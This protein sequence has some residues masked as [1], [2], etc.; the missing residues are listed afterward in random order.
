M[1]QRIRTAVRVEGIVQGVGFRPFV[2]R[3]A[4]ELSLAGFVNNHGAGVTIEVEGDPATVLHPSP[5]GTCRIWPIRSPLGKGR[6]NGPELL[7]PL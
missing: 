4:S 2:Y 5:D 7:A 1:N 6:P 3:L